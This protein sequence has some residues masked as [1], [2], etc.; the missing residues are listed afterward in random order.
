MDAGVSAKKGSFAEMNVVPLID[1]LLVLIIIFMV[2]S[3]VTPRGH[4]ALLPRTASIEL[5]RRDAVVVVQLLASG[6]LKVNGEDQT[7]DGLGGRI[8]QIFAQ[9]AE[10]VAF[11]K[12]DVAVEFASVVR[13]IDIMRSHGVEKVGLITAKLETSR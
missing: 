7:W 8:E 1:I 3:P 9:R 4:E 13:A 6:Q 2:I 10:R 12:S 11:V 5:P